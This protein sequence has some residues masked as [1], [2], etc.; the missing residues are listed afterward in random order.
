MMTRH[1]IME[2]FAFMRVNILGP[3]PGP[4]RKGGGK[5]RLQLNFKKKIEIRAATPS[6][7][8]EAFVLDSFYF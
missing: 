3:H 6:R 4:P 7:P 2:S 8:A 1:A 5:E